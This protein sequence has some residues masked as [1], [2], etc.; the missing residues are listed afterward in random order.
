MNNITDKIYKTYGKTCTIGQ[1]FPT[2]NYGKTYEVLSDGESWV[3]KIIPAEDLARIREILH[4]QHYLA[5]DIFCGKK[6]KS[7][8]ETA[9]SGH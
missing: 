6:R 8:P 5:S 3:V 4:L 2:G 9:I 7:P 1:E